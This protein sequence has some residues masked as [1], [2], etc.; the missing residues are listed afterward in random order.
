M[1][2][3]VAVPSGQDASLVEV[4][5]EPDVARFR[6]LTPDIDPELGDLGYGDV[7]LD[8][9]ILCRAYAVPTLSDLDAPPERIVISFMSAQTPFGEANPEVTQFF[10]VFSLKG[11]D[12][13]WE[14][15]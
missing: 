6:F 13:I 10:E 9:A 8:F 11:N 3:D 2:G 12:C 7:E 14:Q 1:A 15:F 5:L 4:I